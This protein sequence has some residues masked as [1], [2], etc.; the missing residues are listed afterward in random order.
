MDFPLSKMHNGF[1]FMFH[2]KNKDVI[3]A[4]CILT[5]MLITVRSMCV[6]KGA[7]TITKAKHILMK[8]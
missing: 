3:M 5:R 8:T 6:S 7:Y 1:W 2:K 4:R